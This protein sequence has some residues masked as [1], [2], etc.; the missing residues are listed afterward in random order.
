[1]LVVLLDV[2]TTT[3]AV[4]AGASAGAPPGVEAEND[5]LRELVALPEHLVAGP[6]EA[7]AAWR[8]GHE[9]VARV[10]PT[11]VFSEFSR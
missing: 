11:Q 9:R 5:G 1:M 3:T 6:H 10:H 7:S 2:V 4:R 8:Q